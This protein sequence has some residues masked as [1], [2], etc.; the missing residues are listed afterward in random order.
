MPGPTRGRLP[1]GT[2]LGSDSG[3]VRGLQGAPHLC[4]SST[5]KPAPQPVPW[6][7]SRGSG[8]NPGG[9]Q[10]PA[11]PALGALRQTWWME[12]P[13]ATACPPRSPT[14]HHRESPRLHDKAQDALNSEGRAACGTCSN[15]AECAAS[16]LTCALRQRS[17]EAEGH[18]L[19][20]DTAGQDGTEAAPN[21]GAGGGHRRAIAEPQD[22]HHGPQQGHLGPGRGALGLQEEGG[23]R[24]PR[25]LPAALGT[26]PGAILPGAAAAPGG[27][28]SGTGDPRRLTERTGACLPPP[29]HPQARPASLW[30]TRNSSRSAACPAGHTGLATGHQPPGHSHA[31]D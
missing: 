18:S 28:G 14:T 23:Q 21:V 25:L 30:G 9:R 15:R 13:P 24:S 12:P 5:P 16:S 2:H 29:G 17:Q 6:G 10:T 3:L 31:G 1:L 22:R 19:D 20:A 4:P 7:W 27:P 11:S 26:Q 8:G